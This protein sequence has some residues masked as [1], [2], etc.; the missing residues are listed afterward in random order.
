V[1]PYR[2]KQMPDRTSDVKDVQWIVVFLQR[3]M[4]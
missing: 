2:I 3:G 4:F 1:N